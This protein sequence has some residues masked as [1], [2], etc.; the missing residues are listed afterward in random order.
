MQL[1]KTSPHRIRL[2]AEDIHTGS[3]PRLGFYFLLVT[4]SLI[5]A[6]G[7]VANSTAVIIGAM[8]VSPLMTP[9]FGIALG[10]LRG[11]NTLFWRS[12]T[13]EVMGIVLAVGVSFLLGARL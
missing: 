8:L 5:G 11:D 13:A 10:M 3:D 2:V 12:L 9:I 4:A 1:I 7:L 6:I